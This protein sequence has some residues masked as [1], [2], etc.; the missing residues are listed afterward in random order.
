[1]AGI[2]PIKNKIERT[3]PPQHKNNKN[4]SLLLNQQSVG[5]AQK[6]FVPSSCLTY[7]KKS[8][9]GKIPWCPI[10]PKTCTPK[11]QNAAR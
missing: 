1:M 7:C 8:M 11:D 9:V 6:R 3:A 4:P 5:A 10:S 2:N